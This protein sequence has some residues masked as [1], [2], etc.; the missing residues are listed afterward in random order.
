M[1]ELNINPE[2]AQG[3]LFIISWFTL[4][5]KRSYLRNLS[6]CRKIRNRWGKYIANRQD[7]PN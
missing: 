5:L 2:G 6:W 4:N 1:L 7:Q 3:A